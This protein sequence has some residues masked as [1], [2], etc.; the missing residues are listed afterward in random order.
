MS[1]SQ[2][3][4]RTRRYCKYWLDGIETLLASA[5]ATGFRSDSPGLFWQL[6]PWI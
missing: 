4:L 3:H 5:S 1:V 6:K 2:A